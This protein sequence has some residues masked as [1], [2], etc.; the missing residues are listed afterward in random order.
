MSLAELEAEVQKL[1]PSELSAFTRWLDEYAAS[2]WDD[3]IARDVEA[4]RLNKL[5][6]KVDA[7][8][9]SGKCKEL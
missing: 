1:S 7:D 2:Q 9:Q 6:A 3:Q 8:F 5:L 4:G